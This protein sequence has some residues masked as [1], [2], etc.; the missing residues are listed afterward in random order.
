MDTFECVKEA[1]TEMRFTELQAVADAAGL[2]INTLYHIKQG[3][4]WRPSYTTV[5]K[6]DAAIKEIQRG[7]RK[8]G[9]ST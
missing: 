6:L 3:K 1:I 7:K 5:S 2:H 8:K 4:T 9:V